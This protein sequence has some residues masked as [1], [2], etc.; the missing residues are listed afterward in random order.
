M[1]RKR[2]N[3]RQDAE[4]RQSEDAAL[5]ADWQTSQEA[6]L[7]ETGSHT[8][9][10]LSKGWIGSFLYL[11]LI[12]WWFYECWQGKWRGVDKMTTSIF[13]LIL[14]ISCQQHVF[15]KKHVISFLIL[16]RESFQQNTDSSTVSKNTTNIEYC[17]ISP[18]SKNI[19]DLLLGKQLVLAF[20]M[21]YRS[22]LPKLQ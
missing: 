1:E 22:V 7:T 4:V 3:P 11:T 18:N 9:V 19:L 16:K 5:L 21:S 12:V 6:R 13:L 8:M 2:P 15:C 20:K 14:C 10:A 17:I